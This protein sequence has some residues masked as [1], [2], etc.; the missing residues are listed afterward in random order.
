MGGSKNKSLSNPNGKLCILRVNA[1][2]V[3]YISVKPQRLPTSA[4]MRNRTFIALSETKLDKSVNAAEFLLV[5]FE[6]NVIRKDRNLHGGGVTFSNNYGTHSSQWKSHISLSQHL[7]PTS[8][9]HFSVATLGGGGPL[10]PPYKLPLTSA[11][12][13]R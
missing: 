1:N 5:N 10:Q 9:W 4:I 13:L 6:D 2:S 7:K 3:N 8:A 11:I 12:G